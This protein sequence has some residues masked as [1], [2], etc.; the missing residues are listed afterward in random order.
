ML[1]IVELG[2]V[3]KRKTNDVV[4]TTAWTLLLVFCER[5]RIKPSAYATMGKAY[6]AKKAI[7]RIGEVMRPAFGLKEHPIHSYSK[8]EKLWEARFRIAT[9][10]EMRGRR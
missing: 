5:G 7:E 4:P 8:R 1:K 10:D 6:G 3:D 9:R 2:F